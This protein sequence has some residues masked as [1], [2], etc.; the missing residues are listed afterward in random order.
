MGLPENGK[1]I[2][3][4]R[5]EAHQRVPRGFARG[6]RRSDRCADTQRRNHPR[7]G[8]SAHIGLVALDPLAS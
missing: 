5:A 8:V 4:G 6:F 1:H 3:G 7:A 2:D